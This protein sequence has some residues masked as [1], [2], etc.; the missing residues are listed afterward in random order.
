MIAEFGQNARW[1]AS[2]MLLGNRV[3]ITVAGLPKAISGVDAFITEK[4]FN[5]ASNNRLDETT[6]GIGCSYIKNWRKNLYVF[7]D[8]TILNFKR[9]FT[10]FF[11]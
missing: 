2:G 5:V 11:F 9:D 10:K 6:P 4:T 3:R 8:R 1:V 7:S